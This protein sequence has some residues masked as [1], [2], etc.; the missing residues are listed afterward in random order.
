MNLQ[1]LLAAVPHIAGMVVVLLALTSLW[2]L[3]A[4]AARL[5]ALVERPAAPAPALPPQ[6]SAPPPE[7]IHVDDEDA[8]VVAATVAML[9]AGTHRIIAIRP[10]MSA[11]GQQGRQDIHASRRLR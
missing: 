6:P 9:V 4:I 11:W 10:V 5:V 8:A 3:S 7:T 2:A 1:N